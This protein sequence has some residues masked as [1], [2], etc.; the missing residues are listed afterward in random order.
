MF[1]FLRTAMKAA[2]STRVGT[3]PS[4]LVARDGLTKVHGEGTATQA[5]PITGRWIKVDNMTIDGSMARCA[6]VEQCTQDA[7]DHGIGYWSFDL[8]FRISSGV[9]ER[10]CY[11]GAHD[12]V[13]WFSV[14][15]EDVSYVYEG[16]LL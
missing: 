7:F 15:D 4:S 10:V 9:W 11:P 8:H 6:A 16:S 3:T 13:T 5:I 14:T 2:T 1:C 12:D